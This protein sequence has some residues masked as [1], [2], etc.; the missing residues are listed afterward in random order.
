MEVY[1]SV[2]RVVEF[3]NGRMDPA[4]VLLGTDSDDTE[5]RHG[6]VYPSPAE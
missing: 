1:I 5:E 3:I 6:A 2:R 4:E